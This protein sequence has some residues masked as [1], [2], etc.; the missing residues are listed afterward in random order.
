V[1]ARQRESPA[2][3]RFEQP[4]NQPGGQPTQQQNHQD[5][6][7]T[8]NGSRDTI[9]QPGEQIDERLAEGLAPRASVGKLLEREREPGVGKDEED[10]P[11]K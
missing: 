6:E 4:P 11:E 5:D 7:Q 9:G 3:H 10:D 2:L 8:G 1:E